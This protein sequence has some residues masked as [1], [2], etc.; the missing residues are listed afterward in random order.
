MTF[1][2]DGNL[3]LVL[4]TVQPRVVSFGLASGS[5]WLGMVAL[6]AA[7]FLVYALLA[8]LYHCFGLDWSLTTR[9]WIGH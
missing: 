3:K 4:T 1:A 9:K 5:S 8:K 6:L 7:V 2:I